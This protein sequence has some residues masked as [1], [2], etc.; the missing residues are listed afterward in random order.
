M[1][2]DF[3]NEFVD[4]RRLSTVLE[5]GIATAKKEFIT[6]IAD[7]HCHIQTF[8]DNITQ[9]IATGFGKDVRMFCAVVDIREGDRV[10]RYLEDESPLEY[11]VVGIKKW[12][13]YSDND[14]IEVSIR[15]FIS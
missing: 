15:A 4:V 1:L 11:R 13:N 5:S 8:D 2:E 7:L 14:H 12:S 9:D 10:I 3:Y 6:N